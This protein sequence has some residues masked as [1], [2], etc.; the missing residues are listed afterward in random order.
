MNKKVGIILIIVLVVGLLAAAFFLFKKKKD[1]MDPTGSN[2]V[3]D[4][5]D[6]SGAGNSLPTINTPTH[7]NVGNT[8]EGFLDGVLDFLGIGNNNAG[9]GTWGIQGQVNNN[10]GNGAWGISNNVAAG[11]A[12]ATAGLLG[13]AALNVGSGAGAIIAASFPLKKGSKNNYV[14]MIQTAVNQSI[15]K[16]QIRSSMLV[17]D[18]NW[19]TNTDAAVKQ[20]FPTG[21]ISLSLYNAVADRVKIG[22]GLK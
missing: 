2:A 12:N 21:I 22:K 18:G 4:P 13:N 11:A 10:T 14:K 3:E 7:T 20:I 1:A 19:G 5:N 9:N 6:L 15:S 16:G 17:V 8:G